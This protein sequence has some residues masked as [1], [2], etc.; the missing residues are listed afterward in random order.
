MLRPRTYTGEDTVEI[1][2]HAGP[3]ILGRIL[4]L[5]IDSGARPA[6]PGSSLFALT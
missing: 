6:G 3:V 5:A 2:A 4:K 1:S